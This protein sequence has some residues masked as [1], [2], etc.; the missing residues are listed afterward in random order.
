LVKLVKA[1]RIENSELRDQAMRAAI[2]VALNLAEGAN[3]DRRAALNH[4]RIARGSAGEV[5]AAYE[6]ASALGE[7]VDSASVMALAGRITAM[8]RGVISRGG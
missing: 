2:S 4:F 8:L 3:R 1:Q 5:G 7:S 6:I